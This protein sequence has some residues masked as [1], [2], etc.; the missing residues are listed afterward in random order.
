MLNPLLARFDNQPILVTTD[1]RGIFESCLHQAAL[2]LERLNAAVDKPKMAEDGEDEFWFADDDWRSFLRPYVV[3]DGILQIPVKGVLLHDLPYAFGSWA[4]G[5]P[6]IWQAFKRGMGDSSVRGIALV[7]DSPGGEVAGNFDLVDKMYAMKGEKPVRAYAAESA[8][9]A[10][11]S[12]ASVANKITVSRTGGVGS[13][14][15]VTA[16]IDYSKALDKAGIKVT[17]IHFGKHK[18]DGNP[19]EPL[20]DDVRERIATRISELGEVFVDTVA[21]NRGM[22]AQ[23]IRD[24]EALTYTASQAVENGLA[25]DIGALD[26]ALAE[27]A[28]DLSL[29]P[30]D[31]EMDPKTEKGAA[32]QAA[33][34]QLDAARAAGVSEGMAQGRQEERARIAGILDSD[35]GKKRPKAAR[36]LALK[37][38]MSV[39]E[40]LAHL[41]DFPEEQATVTQPDPNASKGKDG[42]A[43]DFATAMKTGNPEVGAEHPQTETNDRRERLRAAAAAAG[44]LKV[45]DK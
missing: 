35:E 33:Q 22:D 21:R 18:V 13:I 38:S 1:F 8:Y 15:V 5:Y 29:E 39:P 24:T 42:A 44:R 6:Y 32:P 17:F 4:T 28:V 14:G 12:I 27:F 25:D 45:V 26:D 3:R 19:Y 20:P 36:S 11:Y 9:S 23:K 10:A 16:H 34:E 31:E 43:A 30:K 41:A 7:C 37:G 2:Q 40:A